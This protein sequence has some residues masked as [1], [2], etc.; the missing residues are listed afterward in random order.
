MKL[1][2]LVCSLL[3]VTVGVIIGITV[4]S[5][6]AA[7]GVGESGPWVIQSGAY[8]GP[9]SGTG[10]FYTIRM[11]QDTGETWVL[12]VK[13]DADKDE[14]LQLPHRDKSEGAGGRR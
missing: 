5:A 11:N 6:R 12:A 7:D 8:G 3:C 9:M 14:W 2:I 4:H 13:D 10:R 1:K